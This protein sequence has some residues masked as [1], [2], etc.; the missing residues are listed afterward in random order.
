MSTDEPENSEK[1]VLAFVPWY[2]DECDD[3]IGYM[4]HTVPSNLIL[5]QP[6][7]EARRDV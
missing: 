6:C 3:L 4:Y 2:C 7:F 1:V 5:C